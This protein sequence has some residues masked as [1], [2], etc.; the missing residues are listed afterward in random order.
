MRN[1]FGKVG[2]FA[3]IAA[4]VLTF[5]LSFSGCSYKGDAKQ[6]LKNLNI[7][8]VL[9]KNGDMKVQETWKVNLENRDKSYRNLYRTFEL[10]SAM[11]DGITDLA[12]YDN[13][14]QVPYKY[15]GDIDPEGVDFVPDNSYYTHQVGRLWEFGWFMPPIDEGTRNFTISYTIK[16]IVAVHADTAVLYNFFIPKNFSIPIADMSCSIQFPS[17]GK[18]DDIRAWLHS[19]ANGNLKIDS[20]DKVSFTVKEIPAETSVELR[21]CTPPQLF[22]ASTRV[23][24]QVVLPQIKAEEQKWYDQYM[25]EKR[26]Q[27]LIGI[28]DAAGALILLIAGIA[29]LVIVR[30]K[31]R[32]HTVE[33]PEYTRDI[34]TGNSPGGIANLFYFYSGGVTKAVE[35]RIFSATLLSL[36]RKGYV[37]F[38][39]TG[40]NFTVTLSGKAKKL[41]LTES[42]QVFF[43]MITTVASSFDNSFTMKQFKKFAESDYKYIDSNI[44]SFLAITKRE[45]TPRGY[46]ETKPLYLTA[47]KAV[48]ILCFIIAISVFSFSASIGSTLVY[49]P[50]SFLLT[51][52]LL[53][54]AGSA[55][56]NLT[57]KGEYE[58][59]VWHGLKKY[60]LEFSRMTE[61]GVPELA[62]WEEYLVYATMMNISKRVC[63]Q[64]KM[65]YPELNDE[66]FLNTNYG[67]TYMYY[68]FGPHMG[69]GTFG[70]MGADFG[71][72]LASTISDISSAATRLANP[73][74]QSGGGGFGSGGGFGGGSFG[75]GGGGFGGGGG[76]GVR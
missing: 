11:A 75:G 28:L 71:S 49:L 24:S 1:F 7:T 43:N 6:E 47:I 20:A 17:G 12:V 8:A 73:P 45:L 13:D 10:N 38:E 23:D 55:K 69:M 27:Y 76:G 15:I 31:N 21:L 39:G 2:K 9:S 32:R 72:T 4:M 33:V 57:E 48:G 66:T 52:V 36:A 42:E 16:N 40:D 64:L 37:S 58:Y 26:R 68:M 29:A 46:Y 3:L 14:H 53:L 41:P 34:P 60:M 67:G 61:Y 35:G 70:D 5:S 25:A 59:G 44:N 74:P 62:L 65:V 50:L 56:Q 30:R 51:G 22:S 19:T 63:D 54:I 18:Q